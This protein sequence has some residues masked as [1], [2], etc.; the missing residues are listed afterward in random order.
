MVIDPSGSSICI[1]ELLTVL[2]RIASRL[3][4]YYELRELMDTEETSQISAQKLASQLYAERGRSLNVLDLGCGEGASLDWF[5]QLDPTI[6]WRGVDIENSPEVAARRQP[7]PRMVSFDGVNLPFPNDS[8][9]IVYCQQ[10]LEHVR[11]PHELTAEVR[12][13]LKPGGVFVG[14]VAYLEPY[15]SYSVFNFTP[16]GMAF[17]LSNAKL[18]PVLLRH[19]SDGFYKIFRQMLGGFGFWSKLSKLSFPYAVVGI[20]GG[21]A[22]ADKRDVNLL[23]IQ[24]AGSFCFV[25]R[26]LG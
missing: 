10:V 12:R 2:K 14:S 7:D 22:G 5:E 23:K 26:K 4:G 25:G 13:V 9:D 16:F 17:V 19:S 8:F 6:Q 1:L 3:P 18:E 24:Y 15:H 21:I 11:F 20:I